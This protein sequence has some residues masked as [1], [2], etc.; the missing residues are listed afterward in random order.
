V[1][2][3]GTIGVDVNP[4]ALLDDLELQIGRRRLGDELRVLAVDRIDPHDGLRVGEKLPV[5]LEGEGQAI[6]ADDQLGR[7]QQDLEGIRRRRRE[8]GRADG[9]KPQCDETGDEG[10]ANARPSCHRR[11]SAGGT[12]APRR[13]AART[14]TP[15]ATPQ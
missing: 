11:A 8:L 2:V 10:R 4:L 14:A 7:R 1:R 13:P 6:L 12:P 5:L 3:T 15:F 9:E